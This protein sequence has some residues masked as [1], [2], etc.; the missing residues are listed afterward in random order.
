MIHAEILIYLKNMLL[1][2]MRLNLQNLS[3]TEI[4]DI[5]I[6]EYDEIDITAFNGNT[7]KWRI[8]RLNIILGYL[9]GLIKFDY[10]Q[11]IIHCHGILSL[12]DHNDILIVILR[13]FI[14][15]RVA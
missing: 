4:H 14:I 6:M 7:E 3:E 1:E 2:Q 12:H 15:N 9:A 8:Y 13:K 11:L 5:L 10:E